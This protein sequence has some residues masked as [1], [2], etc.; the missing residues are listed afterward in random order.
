MKRVGWHNKRCFFL[1]PLLPRRT[2]GAMGSFHPRPQASKKASNQS[3]RQV[4]CHCCCLLR[5][6][7]HL[8]PRGT[9]VAPRALKE[10]RYIH[11]AQNTK[12]PTCPVPR[13]ILSTHLLGG[14]PQQRQQ[15]LCSSLPS[16]DPPTSTKRKNE[17]KNFESNIHPVH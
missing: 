9:E 15:H 8:P 3:S 2:N 5:A 12:L 6:D 11:H 13:Y 4:V 17:K 7:H 16:P 14:S 10:K 1:S